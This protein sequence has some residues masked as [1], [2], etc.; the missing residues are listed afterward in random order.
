DD[1]N[2]LY[3]SETTLI[4]N[5]SD[6]P[7][8]PTQFFHTFLHACVYNDFFQEKKYNLKYSIRLITFVKI[9]NREH[10]VF[11]TCPRLPAVII[12]TRRTVWQKNK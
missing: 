1:D 10:H 5:H 8:L 4:S 11:F 3:Q 9:G 7:G 6:P 2:Q 12:I